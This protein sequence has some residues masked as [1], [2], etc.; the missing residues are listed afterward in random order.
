MLEIIGFSIDRFPLSFY[1]RRSFYT[2]RTDA[3]DRFGTRLEQRFTAK[4]IRV[5]ME[6]A[7]LERIEFIGSMPYWC[8]LGFRKRCAG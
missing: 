4:E 6:Q 5:M 1:R 3:L 2:M 7:G 8:A